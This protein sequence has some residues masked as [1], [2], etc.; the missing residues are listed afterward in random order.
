MGNAAGLEPYSTLNQ[1]P[2]LFPVPVLFIF[3]YP[4]LESEFE[5][6]FDSGD[7]LDLGAQGCCCA[8]ICNHLVETCQADLITEPVAAL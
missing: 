3:Q 6:G 8:A 7:A 4:R 5:V 1:V 2:H